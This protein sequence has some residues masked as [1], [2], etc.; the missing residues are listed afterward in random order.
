MSDLVEL[1]RAFEEKRLGAIHVDLQNGYYTDFTK[2]A[3]PI[4]ND[5]ACTTRE[6]NIPNYW[7]AYTK[8]WAALST[9]GFMK[10]YT[11][12]NL[13]FHKTIAFDKDELVFEKNAQGA[14]DCQRPL[15]NVHL[16]AHNIDTLV[17][18]GV[19]YFACVAETIAGALIKDFRV[20]ALADATD[21]PEAEVATWRKKILNV[22]GDNN[23]APLL[24]VTGSRQF[25]RALQPA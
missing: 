22:L 19:H 5:V 23:R 20:F 18:T 6:H 10:K 1:R 11:G 9:L 17:V 25:K 13:E 8:N 7:V 2:V 15:L 16:R 21:C 24:T 3:F 4:A 12:T 14:F